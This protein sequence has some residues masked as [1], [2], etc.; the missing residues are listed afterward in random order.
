MARKDISFTA[1]DAALRE[2]VH[3]LGALVG[4]VLQDQGGDAFLQEVESDR[5]AAIARRD[6]DPDAAVQLVVRAESRS[7]AQAAELA[8]TQLGRKKADDPAVKELAA[9]LQA[10]SEQAAMTE[11]ERLFFGDPQA[12]QD[13]E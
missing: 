10:Q 1:K 5:Q 3:T 2:D 4:E 13:Q 8:M 9:T 6:G 11:L 12:Q 7:P